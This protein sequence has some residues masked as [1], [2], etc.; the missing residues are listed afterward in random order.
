MPESIHVK[1]P[2]GLQVKARECGLNLSA[3]SRK[4]IADAV[5]KLE[6]KETGIAP[7]TATLPAADSMQ[8]EGT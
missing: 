1:V 7:P 8:G 2:Q 3:I 4:A 5:Q 6:Q